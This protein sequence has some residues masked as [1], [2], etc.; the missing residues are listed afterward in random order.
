[1]NIKEKFTK[2]FGEVLE[3]DY[4]PEIFITASANRWL[5]LVKLN[6]LH[7]LYS[8]FRRF[9]V[10]SIP[11]PDKDK[12]QIVKF[13]NLFFK[14]DIVRKILKSFYDNQPFDVAI[15]K[16]KIC[17]LIFKMGDY[18]IVLAQMKDDRKELS[19]WEVLYNWNDLFLE[20]TVQDDMEL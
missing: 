5:G 15:G 3:E 8:T 20:L 12:I 14:L 11:K 19:Y 2:L 9:S 4:D 1:M 16:K 13:G 17:V 7:N 10:E 18:G 6:M